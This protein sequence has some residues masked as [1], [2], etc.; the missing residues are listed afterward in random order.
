MSFGWRILPVADPYKS[1]SYGFTYV[2]V[3]FSQPGTQL[4][5]VSILAIWDAA[6]YYRRPVVWHYI[7]NP[8]MIAQDTLLG[9]ELFTH[10]LKPLRTSTTCHHVSEETY[11]DY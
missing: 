1:I 10:M 4:R 7:Y 8:E 6:T 5:L 11:E 3:N 9:M 2:Q